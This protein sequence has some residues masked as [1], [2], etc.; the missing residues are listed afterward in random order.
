[1]NQYFL[2][3]KVA[4]LVLSL[5]PLMPLIASETDAATNDAI[6]AISRDYVKSFKHSDSGLRETEMRVNNRLPSIAQSNLESLNLGADRRE[7]ACP[8]AFSGWATAA[9]MVGVALLSGDLRFPGECREVSL[10]N[11]DPHSVIDSLKGQRPYPRQRPYT[12]AN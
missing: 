2:Y 7:N 9:T 11:K 3:C 5:F 4:F 10:S 6:N 12:S 8:G 1:M